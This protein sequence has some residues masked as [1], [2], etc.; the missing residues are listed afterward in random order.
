MAPNAAILT[1]MALTSMASTAASAA[2]CDSKDVSEAERAFVNCVNSAQTGVLQADAAA[3][4][5]DLCESLDNMLAV[6]QGQQERLAECKGR[7]H[8]Q[9]IRDGPK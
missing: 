1:V 8:A 9:K 7:A 6:C 2:K 5:G 4:E 3:A